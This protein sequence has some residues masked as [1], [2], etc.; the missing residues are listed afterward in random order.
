ML[1]YTRCDQKEMFL[2]YFYAKSNRYRKRN[3]TVEDEKLSNNFRFLMYIS[4]FSF[5]NNFKN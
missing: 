1:D 2:I 4:Y 3:N 5:V